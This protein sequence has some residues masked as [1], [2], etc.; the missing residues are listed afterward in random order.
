MP[1]FIL[2]YGRWAEPTLREIPRGKA[3][4][5]ASDAG[6]TQTIRWSSSMFR[7]LMIL[8]CSIGIS[9]CAEE[10]PKYKPIDPETIAAYEKCG[11]VYGG[12]EFSGFGG[13]G[14]SPGKEAATKSLPGFRFNSLSNGM[15]PK[16][17]QVEVPFGLYFGFTAA[18]DAGLKELKNLKSLTTLQLFGTEVSDVGLKDLKDL[19]NLT[20]LGLAFTKVTDVGLK[21]LKDLQNLILLDLGNT[22]VTDAGLKEL[23]VLQN[24][25]FLKLDT[26]KVTDAGLKELKVLEKLTSLDL[27]STQ[28]TD[29]GLTELKNLKHLTKLDL[30]GNKGITDAGSKQLKHLQY[31]TTL[32][33]CGT[34][35]TDAG[36]AQLKHLLPKCEI[37]YDKPKNLP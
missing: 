26:T 2:F 36:V 23:K 29:V 33:V 10:Q 17:P 1:F 14:H 25:A 9:G 13:I 20:T 18:E 6:H 34:G 30:R 37:V 3:G 12:F 19:K 21:Q 22:K 7:C 8:C 11:G 32:N 4:F 31:L 24:L 15:I 27:G 35:V 5:E 28:T 16:L